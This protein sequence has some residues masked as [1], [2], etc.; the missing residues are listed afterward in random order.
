MKIAIITEGYYPELSGVTTSLDAR[1]RVLTQLGH[2]IRIYAPNYAM[3]SNIYPD[4]DAYRGQIAPNL[5]IIPF[6]SKPHKINY[7]LDP[8]PFS[9]SQITEDIRGF[10]PDIL[11]VECPA[12][13][14]LGFLTRPGLKIAAQLHIPKT[15]IYHT[16]YLAYLEDYQKEIRWFALPG[17]ENALRKLMVWIYNSYDVTM[18]PTQETYA[19]LTK[20]KI[21]NLQLG[22]FYGV[23]ADQFVSKPV[24]YP[25]A[26]RPIK[27]FRKVLYVGRL[28]PDKNIVGLLQALD[29]VRQKQDNVRFIFIGG[30][31]TEKVIRTWGKERNDVLLLGR[32]APAEIAPYIA[33]ADVLVTASTKENRPLSILEA[34][35]CGLPVVAPASGGIKDEIENGKTGILFP[36]QDMRALAVAI[37]QLL[38]DKSLRA[39]IGVAAR[40][41]ILS[42]TWEKAVREMVAVWEALLRS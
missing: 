2:R 22:S 1:V 16:N 32:I 40:E 14:F 28:T 23:D 15:A 38:G 20:H 34:M 19:Y 24:E 5:T 37:E 42:Q 7:L 36:P 33:H 11:H 9:F 17:I 3:L 18:V 41:A 8:R 21:R 35:A 6:P 27:D 29:A 4:F 12:R 13:L 31:P 10:A 30:G 26:Y 25:W 39:K